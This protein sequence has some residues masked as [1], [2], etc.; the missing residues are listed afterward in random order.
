MV[1]E[2]RGCGRDALA[3]CR[4]DRQDEWNLMKGSARLADAV[5][6]DNFWAAPN[7]ERSD[8][9]PAMARAGRALSTQ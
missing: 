5:I 7:P 8:A 6:G 1:E 4:L 3:G 2:E 9:P